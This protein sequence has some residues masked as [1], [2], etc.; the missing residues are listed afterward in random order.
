[1]RLDRGSPWELLQGQRSCRGNALAG[2][3]TEVADGADDP[4]LVVCEVAL[5]AVLNHDQVMLRRDGHDLVCGG[6]TQDT[7]TRSRWRRAGGAALCVGG[8]ARCVGGA[9]RCVGGSDRTH[10]RR[11]AVDR[12]SD[13]GLGSAGQRRRDGRWVDRPGARMDINHHGHGVAVCAPTTPSADRDRDVQ[14]APRGEPRTPGQAEL[15]QLAEGHR[16]VCTDSEIIA[17]VCSARKSMGGSG[18]HRAQRHRSET[19]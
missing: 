12:D 13:D 16:C 1:M 10:V 19:A 3:R 17:V 8:A 5:G 9:A 18:T 11:V 15:R 14:H 4:A 6:S 7:L 2:Q